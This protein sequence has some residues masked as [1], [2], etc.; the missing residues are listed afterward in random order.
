MNSKYFFILFFAILISL[1]S[2]L[3]QKSFAQNISNIF[4]NVINF[5][6][7]RSFESKNIEI[8][9]SFMKG[10]E[11]NV[12]IG[13]VKYNIEGKNDFIINSESK[14]GYY[15]GLY[16]DI[17]YVNLGL[18]FSEKR[19]LIRTSEL[20]K[21]FVNRYIIVPIN[22]GIGIGTENFALVIEP[23]IYSGFL[24]STNA[25]DILPIKNFD[26]GF[27][28]KFFAEQRL[29]QKTLLTGGIRYERGGLNNLGSNSQVDKITSNTWYFFGGIKYEL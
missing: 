24:L 13:S 19:S 23:G 28:I 20:E 6:M 1:C 29:S 14:M 8:K 3:I 25:D 21:E 5:S 27:D 17:P 18:L 4:E 15:A 26:L 22:Y 2:S 7:S 9:K 16:F 10:I 12:G 11:L